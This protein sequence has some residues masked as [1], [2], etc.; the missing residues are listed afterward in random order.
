M[1]LRDDERYTA[2]ESYQRRIDTGEWDPH[3]MTEAERLE[4]RRMDAGSAFEMGTPVYKRSRL[5]HFG[6]GLTEST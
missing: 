4:S 5:D 2:E 1:P 6:Y 3:V